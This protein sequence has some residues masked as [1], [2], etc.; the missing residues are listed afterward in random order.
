MIGIQPFFK[1]SCP[2]LSVSI[3]ANAS[4]HFDSLIRLI[5]LIRG[6]QMAAGLIGL[7]RLLPSS[8]GRQLTALLG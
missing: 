6:H 4:I 2:I 7:I 3:Y 8:N 1:G 5:K